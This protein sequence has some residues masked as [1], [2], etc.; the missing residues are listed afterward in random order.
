MR[1][2]ARIE[3]M[4]ELLRRYWVANPDLRLAQI[5]VNLVRSGVPAPH[6]F[7]AEDD[8]LEAALRA[9]VAKLPPDEPDE[10]VVR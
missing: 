10:P 1:D 2:P 5:V 9:E 6:I 3:R 7:Y 8:R 4:V